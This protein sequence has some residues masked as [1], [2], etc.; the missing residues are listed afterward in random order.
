MNKNNR[1]WNMKRKLSNKNYKCPMHVWKAFNLNNSKKNVKN[2]TMR[3]I[4]ER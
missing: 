1:K 2:T 4:F 3:K